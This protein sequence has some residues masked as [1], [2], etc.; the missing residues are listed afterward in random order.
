MNCT[1]QKVEIY[2]TFI[3]VICSISTNHLCTKTEKRLYIFWRLVKTLTASVQDKAASL[4]TRLSE[5]TAWYEKSRRFKYYIIFWKPMFFPFIKIII[6]K[7]I[8]VNSSCWKIMHISLLRWSSKFSAVTASKLPM[9]SNNFKKC[10]LY[11][12]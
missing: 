4:K 3:D 7:I 9:N 2:V 1:V 10:P 12:K 5:C 8:H 11:L 6:M